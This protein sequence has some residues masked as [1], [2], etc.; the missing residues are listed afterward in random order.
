MFIIKKNKI[1]IINIIFLDFFL[2]NFINIDNKYLFKIN[3]K[4]IY[5]KINVKNIY[6]KI[7]IK[8]INIFFKS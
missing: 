6:S 1:I 3:I 2:I 5:L 7:N 8:N 4:I